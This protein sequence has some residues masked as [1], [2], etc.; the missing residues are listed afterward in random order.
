VRRAS[1]KNISEAPG[2]ETDFACGIVVGLAGS[3]H[4]DDDARCKWRKA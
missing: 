3:S 1:A 2:V 4:P